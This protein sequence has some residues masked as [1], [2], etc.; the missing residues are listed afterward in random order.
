LIGKPEGKW[1]LGSS[2]WEGSFRIVRE[3]GMDYVDNINMAK[4][5]D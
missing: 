5:T 1:L 4:E 3:I 2:R